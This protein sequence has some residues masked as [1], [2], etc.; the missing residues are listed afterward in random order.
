MPKARGRNSETW[1]PLLILAAG[2]TLLY[3]LWNILVIFI[4][5]AL[6][7]FI[8]YPVV[9]LFDK[10][11][12]HVFSIISV[13]LL[14]GIALIVTI[15][16]LAPTVTRQYGELV[17]AIPSYTEQ[18]REL[19]DSI[20]E[21]YVALPPR[22]R[23]V[24]DR[25]LLELEQ[26]ALRV[27]RETIPAVF[28]FFTS[29]VALIFVP[30]LAFF[31]LLGYRGYKQMI[32]AVTPRR[33]RDTVNDLLAYTSRTLWNFIRGEF[34]LMSSVGIATGVGLYLVGMPYPA[35]FGVLAGL[36]ELIPN[37]GP[38]ATTVLV[39]AVGLLI[40]PILALKAAGIT[41]AVQLLENS[42]LVPLVMGKAVGLDPVTVAF[43]IFL[44]GSAA[45]ILGAIIAI[46]LAV[47]VKTVVIYFYARDSDLPA[48][49][50][51]FRRPSRR[52]RKAA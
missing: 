1:I 28:A 52:R 23:M 12:P 40:D 22:W 6:F 29:L 47:T 38:I 46:P 45:G 42:L 15:G 49:A 36:L 14:I 43:A 24:A 35:V 5:A 7:A 34:I 33:H 48:R 17:D 9:R 21:R 19:S 2:L 30:L 13:Y 4:L 50:R 25:A 32:V 16:L 27:T 10:K 39:V 8:V 37:F 41:I 11:L 44:G 51:R 31:M 26:T 3:L 20:Q 18:A